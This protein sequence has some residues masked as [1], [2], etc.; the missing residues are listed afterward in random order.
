VNMKP[1]EEKVQLTVTREI[2]HYIQLGFFSK[3]LELLKKHRGSIPSI[4]YEQKINEVQRLLLESTQSDSVIDVYI[5]VQHTASY[6]SNSGIQRVVRQLIKHLLLIADLRIQCISID[7]STLAIRGISHE[8]ALNLSEWNGPSLQDLQDRHNSFKPSIVIIPE[9]VYTSFYPIDSSKAVL[10]VFRK[11]NLKIISIFYDN[12][13]FVVSSYIATSAIHADYVDSVLTSDCI[14]PISSWVA[15]DLLDYSIHVSSLF[16]LT[17]RRKIHPLLLGYTHMQPDSSGEDFRKTRLSPNGYIL[18]VG[19]VAPHKNQLQL[20]ASYQLFR[21]QNP[22]SRLKLVLA[23]NIA[24]DLSDFV[25]NQ[26]SDS[27]VFVKTPSDALLHD[28]YSNCKMVCF[29][30]GEEGFGLP[31][32]EAI[33][34]GKPVIAANFG[35]MLEVSE[36]IGIGCLSVNTLN[37]VELAQA[38]ARLDADITAVGTEYDIQNKSH[39]ISWGQYANQLYTLITKVFSPKQTRKILFNASCLIQQFADDSGFLKAQAGILKGL[40]DLG[41]CSSIVLVKNCEEPSSLIQLAAHELNRINSV[42]NCSIHMADF[43]FYK[44]DS[45]RDSIYIDP[46]ANLS[47][48]PNWCFD[49]EASI[50][51]CLRENGVK[52]CAFFFGGSS[53]RRQVA[54]SPMDARYCEYLSF[55][56]LHNFIFSASYEAEKDLRESASLCSVDINTAY[57]SVKTIHVANESL[58]VVNQSGFELQSRNCSIDSQVKSWERLV[59]HKLVFCYVSS[60]EQDS[61]MMNVIQA[62]ESLPFQLRV[63]AALLLVGRRPDSDTLREVGC[64][65]DKKSILFV[66]NLDSKGIEDALNCSSVSIFASASSD[67]GISASDC[68]QRSIPVMMPYSHAMKGAWQHDSG[69]YLILSE[70]VRDFRD[71]MALMIENPSVVRLLMSQIKNYKTIKWHEY[72]DSFLSEVDVDAFS[73]DHLFSEEVRDVDSFRRRNINLGY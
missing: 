5:Y 16:E 36:S 40:L 11:N 48:N 57:A 39:I 69:F 6:P 14:V 51:A 68:L 17:T 33:R 56:S 72:V 3:S 66:D 44:P 35:A 55:L 49:R 43:S 30:S 32:I 7:F 54:E 58:G 53:S 28:L 45:Y 63:R 22:N 34:Y 60:A 13:P 42:L 8:E 4:V 10:D 27:I 47:L 20:I 18:S 73:S 52:T 12:I 31:I 19:T 24:S 70:G 41:H 50:I 25:V 64:L 29:P 71:A 21:C 67:F 23:G 59:R 38:I 9:L 62:F 46:S 15:R 1:E 65:V 2:N 61:V 37:T 26:Q